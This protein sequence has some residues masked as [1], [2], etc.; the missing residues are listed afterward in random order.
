LFGRGRALVGLDSLEQALVTLE[1]LLE[2]N[3]THGDALQTAGYAATKLNQP[4]KALEYYRMYL[5]LNP[6]SS[7]IRLTVATDLFNNGD[8]MGALQLTDEGLAVGSTDTNLR[9]YAGPFARA[10]A[11]KIERDT[12]AHVPEGRPAEAVELYA[13][14]LGDYEGVCA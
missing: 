12:G 9:L 7:Q 3:A 2:I 6:G 5:E 13:K 11:Q 14:A 4:Q 8:P 10:A 1:K